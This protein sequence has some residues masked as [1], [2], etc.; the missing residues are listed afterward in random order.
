MARQRDYKREYQQRIARGIARGLSRSQARGHGAE[1]KGAVGAT[2]EMPLARLP[3]E[4]RKLR[5]NRS[6]KVMGTMESGQVIR[7]FQGKPGPMLEWF[8]EKVGDSGDYALLGPGG[9][10]HVVSVQVIYQ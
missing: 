1:R 2:R 8:E 4:I 9:D 7:L 10:D 5:S 3:G 6:V